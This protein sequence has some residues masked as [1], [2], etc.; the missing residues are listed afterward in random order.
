MTKRMVL[1]IKRKWQREMKLC[2]E[3]YIVLARTPRQ[4]MWY[5]ERQNNNSMD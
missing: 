4:G 3:M 1:I 5:V 2:S